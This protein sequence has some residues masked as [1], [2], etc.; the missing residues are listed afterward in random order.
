MP[1]GESLSPSLR[2]NTLKTWNLGLRD[3][4]TGKIMTM[5][6]TIIV[7]TTKTISLN[8][9]HS[10]I[11]PKENLPLQ[12]GYHW[13][14]GAGSSCHHSKGIWCTEISSGSADAVRL[15]AKNK[16]YTMESQTI[17]TLDKMRKKKSIFHHKKHHYAYWQQEDKFL[18]FWNVKWQ[19]LC[20]IIY[21]SPACSGCSLCITTKQ[22]GPLYTQGDWSRWRLSAQS[23]LIHL[24]MDKVKCTQ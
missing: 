15:K 3:W 11:R 7:V 6:Q 24:N 18:S 22:E 13:P 5:K 9:H 2:K 1:A 19:T 10:I 14:T 23:E 21:S 17:G 4:D 8:T 16:K 20:H 12:C